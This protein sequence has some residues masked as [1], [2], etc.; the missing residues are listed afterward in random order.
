MIEK[1][2]ECTWHGRDDFAQLFRHSEG[3]QEV[4]NRQLQFQLPVKPKPGI[5]T[6]AGGAMPVAARVTGSMR[7][8]TLGTVPELAAGFR[9]T[10]ASQ[11]T[12]DTPVRVRHARSELLQ[13][14]RAMAADNIR[15]RTHYRSLMK[16]PTCLAAT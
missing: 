5:I 9:R 11:I 7:L 3:A 6:P 14:S 4:R 8:S 12:Q 16:L 15:Q 13:I 1:P 10:A 2:Q